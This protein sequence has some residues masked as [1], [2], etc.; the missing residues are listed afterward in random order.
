ML[1]SIGYDDFL[2]AWGKLNGIRKQESC[3]IQIGTIEQFWPFLD[4][5]KDMNIKSSIFNLSIAK[6]F[7]TCV[8]MIAQSIYY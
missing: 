7:D 5:R 2:E 4:I 1:K 8:Y 3:V 6:T